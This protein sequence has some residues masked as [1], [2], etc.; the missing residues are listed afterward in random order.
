VST[1]K[2]GR[3]NATTRSDVP[4]VGALTGQWVIYTGSVVDV[5]GL[6]WQPYPQENGLC[7][8]CDISD[9]ALEGRSCLAGLGWTGGSWYWLHGAHP[10]SFT[11]APKED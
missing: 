8:A 7:S 11:P 3:L 6:A 9:P 5:H 1:T 2:P 4:P 10:E